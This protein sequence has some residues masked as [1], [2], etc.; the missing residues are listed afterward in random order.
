MHSCIHMH[1]HRIYK[2]EVHLFIEFFCRLTEFGGYQCFCPL[3]ECDILPVNGTNCQ[4][5]QHSLSVFIYCSFI[6]SS[7]LIVRLFVFTYLCLSIFLS[8][9]TVVCSSICLFICLHIH[10]PALCL[11]VCVTSLSQ[12]RIQCCYTGS[13][14]NARTL[15]CCW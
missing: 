4:G 12:K 2:Y 8:L 13:P 7:V 15:N 11:P 3:D 14:E 5:K 6:C 1:M 9:C 10:L